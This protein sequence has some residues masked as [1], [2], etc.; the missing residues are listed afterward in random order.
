MNGDKDAAQLL[1]DHGADVNIADRVRISLLSM[2]V[3][4]Y[5]VQQSWDCEV[6]MDK[7]SFLLALGS[8][9]CRHSCFP[10]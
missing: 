4:A 6:K 3:H 5:A 7:E 10:L 1:L 9:C 8:Y 2:H